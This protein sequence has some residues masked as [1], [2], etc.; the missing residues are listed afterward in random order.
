MGILTHAPDSH[1]SDEE[2]HKWSIL[3]MQMA[4][5][6]QGGW[7]QLWRNCA[8]Q[9]TLDSPLCRGSR[10]GGDSRYSRPKWSH[11]RCIEKGD[12]VKDGGGC[13]VLWVY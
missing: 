6:M 10:H 1:D 5:F 8:L 9:A 2:V 4:W 7:P 13:G 11:T 3:N 12:P